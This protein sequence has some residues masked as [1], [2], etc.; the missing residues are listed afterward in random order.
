MNGAGNNS[1]VNTCAARI[2]DNGGP[3][4]DYS[5]NMNVTR[6][7]C[8]NNG[9]PIRININF[10]NI[11]FGYDFLTIYDGPNTS[12]T[13]LA[14]LTGFQLN[15]PNYFYTSSGTCL[16]IKFTSDAVYNYEDANYYGGF[17]ILVG[18]S[19][20]NCN[21]NLPASDLCDNPV[22]IC[23]VDG[24]CGST[25]GWYTIDR[26]YIDTYAGNSQFCG[27]IENNSWLSFVPSATTVTFQ[28]Q[29]ANC[30]IGGSSGGIQF[31]LLQGNC[32]SLT[33]VGNNCW[34]QITANQNLTFTGLTIGSTYRIMVDGF[35]GDICN[36]SLV[37]TSGVQT[38][39]IRDTQ[40]NT[41]GNICEGECLN[42]TL[43]SSST[44]TSYSW[45]SVPAGV[46]G[47]TSTVSVCPSQNMIVS[48]TITGACGASNTVSF[49]IT[50]KPIPIVSVN[51]NPVVMC[52]GQSTG[53]TLTSS[54]ASTTYTWTVVQNGVTGATNG[55]GLGT[56]AN[57]SY[58]LNQ[59]LTNSNSIS[60]TATYTITPVTNGCNGTPLTITVTVDP[61][62][63]V[64]LPSNQI[65]C[66]GQ[67]TSAVNFTGTNG[68]T[69]SWSNNNTSTGLSASG[70]G[71]ISS[72]IGLNSGTT[73]NVSTIT[74][75]PTFG[76]CPGSPQ[77]FTITVTPPPSVTAPISQTICAGASTSTI[78]FTGTATTYNWT[79]SNTAIG[80]GAN[81]TG[82]IPSFVGT[83]TGSTP[84]SGTITVT[85][86]S[87]TCSGTPIT[88]TITINPIPT[89][90]IP[91]N[92][93][94]CAGQSTTLITFAGT[95]G[96]TLSWSNDN[97]STG[98][99]SSGNGDISSFVATNST[100][101]TITST[102][103]VT[104]TLG[105]CSGTPI[106]FTI[107]VAITPTIIAPSS[108]TICA[109]S[110]TTAINFTGTATTYNWTNSN[111]AIGLGAN[112]TGDIA[113][114]VGTNNGTTPISGTITVTPTS[115]TCSGATITF[116]ITINP[117]VTPTFT[118]LGPYCLNDTPGTLPLNS[119]NAS[120]VSGTWNPTTVN[121]NILGT[122]TY[123][124]TPTAN[125]CAST[126]TMSITIASSLTP[127]FTQLGPFCQNTSSITLPS[128][129]T[130][131]PSI[132][133]IWNPSSVNTSTIGTSTYTF[134]PN[135]Y[136]CAA[137]VTM[138]IQTISNPTIT[139]NP[140]TICSGQTVTIIPTV[141][142][143][144]GT[145][146]WSNNQTTSTITVSPTSTTSYSLLYSLTGCN[147]NS[148]VSITVNPNVTPTFG[149]LGPYCQNQTPGVLNTTSL[150]SITGT[151]NPATISTTTVGNQTYTFTPT[152]GVCATNYTQTIL[153]NP[154]VNPTFNP[155]GPLCQ[156]DANPSLPISSTNTPSITGTWN[157]ASI[158]TS[159]IGNTNYTFTPTSGQCASTTNLSVSVIASPVL[160]IN[161]NVVAG[162][163][164]LIS[165]LSTQSIPNATYNWTSNGI[166]LGSTPTLN[167]TFSNAGCFDIGLTV[168]LGACQS[169]TTLN[170]LICVEAA[171]IALF[172]VFPNSFSSSTETAQFNNNSIGATSYSW[173]FGDGQTS[174]EENPSH[175]Y[176][177]INSNILATLTAVSSLGCTSSFSVVISYQEE[178][179]FYVPNTF[180][181]DEDEF[182]QTWG[183]VFS[184]GFDEFNFNLYVYNRWGEVV[185]ESKDAK[186]RWD[187]NYGTS[188]LKCP[189]GIYTW[190]ID[191]KPIETDEKLTITG[192]VNLLR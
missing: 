24:Y 158:S 1:T 166:N 83:N 104:P 110:S 99:A 65:N 69:F 14:T 76:V 20:Q 8:S 115:G 137:T 149:V 63:T 178:T 68:A 139:L 156:N 145:Y 111:T 117:S 132:S 167:T 43:Q 138:S 136:Q 109:G 127:T 102:I 186:G 103:T 162:C 122:Q 164:P 12:S 181:P 16:T 19:P 142:P 130:N 70:S 107:T 191:Y 157:P 80:L 87:G 150:N 112:G 170:D 55:N 84:I 187:G 6:T 151:W 67:S 125:Q 120:S 147:T 60:G 188:G 22:Q 177:G 118:Q 192:Q 134:T 13:T 143:S 18:C 73:N 119:T 25:N 190:K 35:A 133:G 116:T 48:C 89:V 75:T 50:V 171:P 165:T 33:R 78:N 161:A 135:A 11:E 108:Q 189:Q 44:P 152:A 91:Q 100:S 101:N 62:P 15:N 169:S 52:S 4:N 146:L 172:N 2:L 173:D 56:G 174:T 54:I 129:S 82:D 74:I 7:F 10:L 64:T 182:N 59:T 45:S 23:D 160:S 92:Q 71:N 124:F 66:A 180:T 61:T 153:V 42:L 5:S 140:Q 144:G 97:T 85:P 47:S 37:A 185:W 148:T 36:Y 155:I 159:T 106:T 34:N 141:N 88:F 114:F 57:S 26:Q 58:N 113:S 31:V 39:S 105:T 21:G 96:A 93:I 28:L 30:I 95:A 126:V 17:N 128:N 77:N 79:N 27:S 179:I 98:L 29:L 51:P 176:T 3:S 40:G 94:L 49:P 38:V 121:T 46:T 183:P 154:L 163:A 184:K 9:G 131:T 72:F 86:T 123:T 175:I 90:T 41:S 32:G 168:S 53:I 81:G